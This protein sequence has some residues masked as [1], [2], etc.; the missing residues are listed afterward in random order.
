MF[1]EGD[2]AKVDQKT[3]GKSTGVI[4]KVVILSG[5]ATNRSAQLLKLHPKSTVL[6]FINVSLSLIHYGF[7]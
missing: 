5:G 6:T 7:D 2:S 1:F 3:K 4:A